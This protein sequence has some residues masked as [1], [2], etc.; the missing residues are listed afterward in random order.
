MLGGGL[1]SGVSRMAISPRGAG[2]TV[3]CILFPPPL[4]CSMFRES[5]GGG[6]Q[7]IGAFLPSDAGVGE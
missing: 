5:A 6:F 7:Q 2:P 4:P 1:Y 3:A